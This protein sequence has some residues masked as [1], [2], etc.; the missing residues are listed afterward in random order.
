MDEAIYV[1][2]PYDFRDRLSEYFD[3]EGR[4]LKPE[5]ITLTL[6]VRR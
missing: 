6:T 1:N 5:D 3:W 4:N 2:S